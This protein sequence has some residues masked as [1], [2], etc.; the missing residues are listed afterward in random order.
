GVKPIKL[1]VTTEYG[2][3]NEFTKSVT[4]NPDITVF[5]PNAFYPGTDLDGKKT[6]CPNG[7]ME[8]N[9]TFKPAAK[10]FQ[11]IEIFVFN[12][13][14]QQVYHRIFG[15]NDLIEGWNGR[16]NNNGIECQQDVYIYQINATSYSSKTYKY[17]GSV[18]LMR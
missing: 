4:I 5:I 14:G 1:Q 16:I 3:V 6:P 11:T 9:S 15:A 8:C 2:C 17:S 18:T 13:W 12:R 10:G 7:D